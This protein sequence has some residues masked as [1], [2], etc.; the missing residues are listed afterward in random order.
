MSTR[1]RMLF[2]RYK[3]S[4]CFSGKGKKV[5][6]LPQLPGIYNIYRKNVP[7][8]SDLQQYGRQGIKCRKENAHESIVHHIHR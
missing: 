7:I 8:I 3:K 2:H 4:I 5:P 6:L 1:S